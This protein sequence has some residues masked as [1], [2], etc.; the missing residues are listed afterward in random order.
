MATLSYDHFET[1][2]ELLATI[3][4]LS[5]NHRETLASEHILAKENSFCVLCEF[6][7]E[8]KMLPKL[9]YHRSDHLALNFLPF[10]F[11]LVGL[12]QFQTPPSLNW[13]QSFGRCIFFTSDAFQIQS[14]SS[15]V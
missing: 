9:T 6:V 5:V 10:C 14:Q 1:P 4:E 11:P 3:R 15:N 2:F 13:N 12:W 7:K 8:M